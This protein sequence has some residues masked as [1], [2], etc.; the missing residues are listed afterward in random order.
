MKIL[1]QLL[2]GILVIGLVF[3]LITKPELL[4]DP[5]KKN[6]AAEGF[7][8]FYSDYRTS[9][10]KTR[11]A[12][13][14]II[15]IPDTSDELVLRLRRREL[16]VAAPAAATWRGQKI[17]R[18]FEAGKTIKQVLQDYADQEQ[19]QL[20]WALPRD[21]VVKEYFVTNGSLVE[22]LQEMTVTISPD[23]KQPIF[24]FFCP[25]ARALVVTYLTD[26]FFQQNCVATGPNP[27]QL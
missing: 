16:Q 7:S 14:F 10:Q 6:A 12:S 24:G 21:Y 25:N 19:M 27:Y 8:R 9:L 23:F 20:F 26:P 3:L 1:L 18:R 22:A 15:T 13:D 4:F 5:T 17:R 2:V 11:D